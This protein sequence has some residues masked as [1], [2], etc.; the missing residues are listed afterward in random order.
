MMSLRLPPPLL[1]L[2][3]PLPSPPFPFFFTNRGVVELVELVELVLSSCRH[4]LQSLISFNS[5]A[6]SNMLQVIW[7]IVFG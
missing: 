6:S 4:Q 5:Y 1:C 2:P 3:P 7:L